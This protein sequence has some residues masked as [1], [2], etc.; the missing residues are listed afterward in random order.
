MVNSV[1]I[2]GNT[3]RDFEC[4]VTN[5][6]TTVVSFGVALNDRRKNPQTGEWEDV[7]QFFDVTAFGERWE[8]LARYVPKGSKV[9][10]QGKLH[11]GA[12][13]TDD[14]GKRSKVDIIA[15]E[16]ELP[17]RPPEDRQQQPYQQPQ[18]QQPQ[19]YQQPQ[20]QAYQQAYEMPRFE[21]VPG[22]YADESIPF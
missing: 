7:P 3:T 16:I 11:Y 15:Q 13:Q 8:K 14:G 9:T 4:R 20:T 5:H 12:W 1:V 6:G 2:A 19:Q 17:P 21:E 22:A 18:P 10:I